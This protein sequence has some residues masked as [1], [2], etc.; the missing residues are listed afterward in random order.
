MDTSCKKKVLMVVH[1][2]G[3]GGVRTTVT[4]LSNALYKRG[5]DVT[6][7][8]TSNKVLKPDDL[9]PE[10][11]FFAKEERQ[12]KIFSK[13]PYFKHFWGSGMW[14]TR[15]PPQKLYKHFIGNEKYDIEI[16]QFFG[17]PL[18]VVYGSPNKNSKKIAW[19]H[20]DFAYGETKGFLS[21]FKTSEE[22][23][24]AYK[25]FDAVICASEGVKD[26]FEKEIGRK[27]NNF[28]LYNLNDRAKIKA[29]AEEEVDVKKEKFT[30]VFV[31]RLSEEKGVT[32]LLS[33][34][35]KLNADGFDFDCWIVGDGAEKQL[36]DSFVKEN[37]L[38]N[39]RLLGQQKNPYPYIKRADVLVLP[40]KAEAYGLSLA[41][42]LILHTPCLATDCVGP[43]DILDGGKY[44]LLTANDEESIYKGMKKLLS[45]GELLF[46]YRE[47][48]KQ[49]ASFFEEEKII[50]ELEKIIKDL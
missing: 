3:I 23:I 4:N 49:R 16:A 13:L 44:G 48:A 22:A 11:K 35:K 36:A 27:D 19:I 43:R 28:V 15:Q 7:A 32:R 33:C 17:R 39:V 8:V 5:Y 12:S 29:L 47:M 9:L 38:T 42:A 31:G 18:K 24:T 10:I 41:E 1:S 25:S 14:S 34:V 30:F 6:V 21:A 46:H 20:S 45:D 2:W 50:S 40:S 26:S 37:S